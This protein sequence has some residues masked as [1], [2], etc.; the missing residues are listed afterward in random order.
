[1][2]AF[3]ARIAG[4]PVYLGR[5]VVAVGGVVELHARLTCGLTGRHT[6]ASLKI[7]P[8]QIKG[9]KDLPMSTML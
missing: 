5:L 3:R 6:A 9:Q 7:L 2:A 4:H 8:M 1:M